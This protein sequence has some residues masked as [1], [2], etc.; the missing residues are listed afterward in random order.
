[1]AH[2]RD[3][4]KILACGKITCK[5]GC[6]TVILARDFMQHCRYEHP[7]VIGKCLFCGTFKMEGLPMKQQRD[8]KFACVKANKD[9]AKHI[10]PLS[11][12]LPENMIEG[13]SCVLQCRGEKLQ[14]CKVATACMDKEIVIEASEY[15]NS[16]S[17]GIAYSSILKHNKKSAHHKMYK[18]FWE[19]YDFSFPSW[20]PLSDNK[21]E[22]VAEANLDVAWAKVDFY[23]DLLFYRVIVAPCIFQQ[24]IERL[25]NS[26]NF[27]RL[28]KY[29]AV[30]SDYMHLILAVHKDHY[31]EISVVEENNCQDQFMQFEEEI[32]EKNF[33]RDFLWPAHDHLEFLRIKS[34]FELFDY[35]AYFSKHDYNTRS[36][37]EVSLLPHDDDLDSRQL[38]LKYE[39]IERIKTALR[40][41]KNSYV[42]RPTIRHAPLW[43]SLV[44]K[45]GFYEYIQQ[46]VGNK[47]LIK[48]YNEIIYINGNPH[49]QFKHILDDIPNDLLPLDDQNSLY[50]SCGHITLN[51]D[52]CDREK[53]LNLGPSIICAAKSPVYCD[54]FVP[55]HLFRKIMEQYYY[56]LNSYQV[57]IYLDVKSLLERTE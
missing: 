12:P 24:F 37:T 16:I 5:L 3:I 6:D 28:L 20:L 15:L 57:Q 19:S 43:F 39:L 11:L 21:I 54:H 36:H 51:V 33:I 18:E 29:A 17:N 47:T 1:M 41:R 22:Y 14:I 7:T 53:Y 30:R 23:D 9:A 55:S 2:R 46:F 42:L 56:K 44:T 38:Y 40:F 45:G 35:I 34:P 32:K 25:E 49:L 48:F 27:C 50:Y 52:D 31:A 10:K 26:A 8:H 13:R 4:S